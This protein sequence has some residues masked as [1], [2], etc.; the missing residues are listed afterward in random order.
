MIMD[1]GDWVRICS[2]VQLA[3]EVKQARG[4]GAV[5]PLV[6]VADHETLVEGGAGWTEKRAPTAVAMAHVKHLKR[7]N[8]QFTFV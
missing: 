5:D 2:V 1:D 3:V 6:P 7:S 4:G 8:H